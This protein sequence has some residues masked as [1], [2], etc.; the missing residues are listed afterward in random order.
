MI[1]KT[2]PNTNEKFSHQYAHTHLPYVLAEAATYLRETSVDQSDAWLRGFGESGIR[3]PLPLPAIKANAKQVL[4]AGRLLWLA[5]PRSWD[6]LRHSHLQ[7]AG[8]GLRRSSLF[9][10]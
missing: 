2:M 9:R 7:N 8:H 6:V 1:L 3:L 4:C 5:S 10:F